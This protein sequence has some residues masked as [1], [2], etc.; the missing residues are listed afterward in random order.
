MLTAIVNGPQ[1]SPFF[2]PGR[3]GARQ[4]DRIRGD[5]GPPPLHSSTSPSTQPSIFPLLYLLYLSVP[6][7]SI[8]ARLHLS[9]SLLL[10]FSSHHSLLLA[11]LSPLLSPLSPPWQLQDNLCPHCFYLSAGTAYPPLPTFVLDQDIPLDPG[12]SPITGL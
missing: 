9:S 3:C 5:P 1:G 4:Q 6:L 8:P 2:H 11:T 10:Y 7:L 12:P